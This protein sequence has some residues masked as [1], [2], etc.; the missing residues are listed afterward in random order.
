MPGHYLDTNNDIDNDN[1]YDEDYDDYEEPIEE[2]AEIPENP[3][4]YGLRLNPY[5]NK[6]IKCY[7]CFCD[8]EKDK[9]LLADDQK[10]YCSDCWD[11]TINVDNQAGEIDDD[12][13]RV[14]ID[15]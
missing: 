14:P 15:F 3:Y 2:T 8:M 6:K 7:E 10:Y 5:A 11:G 1:D 4:A 12:Y 9:D 13:D